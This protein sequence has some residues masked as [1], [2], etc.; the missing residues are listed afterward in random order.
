MEH[1]FFGA[2]DV[3]LDQRRSPE[4]QSLAEFVSASDLHVDALPVGD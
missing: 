3:H 1:L 2:F 4:P